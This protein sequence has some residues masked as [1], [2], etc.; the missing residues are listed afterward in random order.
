MQM[1][2][3]LDVRTDAFQLWLA[4]ALVAVGLTTSK[5]HRVALRPL[6]VWLYMWSTVLCCDTTNAWLCAHLL[7]T[8]SVASGAGTMR[9]C[10]RAVAMHL[11]PATTAAP[12]C[13]GHLHRCDQHRA[14]L[15]LYN[16]PVCC[17]DSDGSCSFCVWMRRGIHQHTPYASPGV[18]SAMSRWRCQSTHHGMLCTHKSALHVGQPCRRPSP[19][20]ACC[21][22]GDSY[23]W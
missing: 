9:V 8:T 13:A 22:C 1:I 15:V 5:H 19:N 3:K 10:C 20:A 21:R 16:L 23:S 7:C 12:E 17:A 11:H 18:P 6:S 2:S 4:D 14:M